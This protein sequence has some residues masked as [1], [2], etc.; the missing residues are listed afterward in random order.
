VEA[1]ER[2]GESFPERM[3]EVS[4]RM[5]EAFRSKGS[6]VRARIEP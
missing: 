3:I 5:T 2:V 1:I 6:F 4:L